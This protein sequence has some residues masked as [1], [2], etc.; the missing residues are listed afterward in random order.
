MTPEEWDSG[1][2]PK[3]TGTWNLHTATQGMDLSFF[4]M[5]GSIAG[6]AGSLGQANYA[7]SNTFLTGLATYRRQRGLPASVLNLGP[8]ED[9]GIISE[10][11]DFAQTTS[12]VSAQPITERAVLDAFQVSIDD[13]HP[14][15]QQECSGVLDVGISDKTSRNESASLMRLWGRDARFA[16]HSN[17]GEASLSE[18]V[19]GP[20]NRLREFLNHIHQDPKLLN[21]SEAITEFK[22]NMARLIAGTIANG[23]KLTDEEAAGFAIDSLVAIEM[24]S[25]V[26]RTIHLDVPLSKITKAGNLGSLADH[27]VKLLMV[28]YKLGSV[29]E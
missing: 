6:S 21:K 19:D 29:G 25:W 10:R 7:A 22:L 26:R 12:V 16:M 28:Q 20:E 17:L 15:Q 9:V 8:V 4:V 11:A 18:G 23:Q 14:N 24:R 3:V 2:A 1:L 13:S 5:F 27:I